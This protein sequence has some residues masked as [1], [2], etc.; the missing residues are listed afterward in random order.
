MPVAQDILLRQSFG[1]A[2]SIFA[3]VTE[4]KDS[5]KRAKSAC[6]RAAMLLKEFA[7]VMLGSALSASVYKLLFLLKWRMQHGSARGMNQPS[8]TYRHGFAVVG[9]GLHDVLSALTT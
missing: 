7:S 6:C 9:C 3:T 4:A 5:C 1:L 8:T 2:R